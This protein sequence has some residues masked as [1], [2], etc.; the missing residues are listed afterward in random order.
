MHI[1]S[2]LVSLALT[3]LLTPLISAFSL[4]GSTIIDS[5]GNPFVMKGINHAYAFYRQQNQAFADIKS[6]GSNTI[7]I[8]L[9]GTDTLENIKFVIEESKKNKLV[10]V[11]ENHD[12]TGYGEN[13]GAKT[14]SAIAD[15]WVSMKDA[16]IGQEDYVILN[17]ANEPFGNTNFQ[18]WT[19]ETTK[20]IE[21]IR[22]A[23]IKNQLMVDGP[24]WG[25]DWSN[26]M[27]QNAPAILASD[28]LKNVVFSVH[29]YGVYKDAAKITSYIDSYLSRNLPII[30]GEFGFTHSDGEVDEATIFRYSAEKNV[31]ILAWSWSGNG[32]GVEYLDLVAGFDKSKPSAWGRQVLDAVKGATEA[33]VFGAGG[34]GAGTGTA[35][36]VAPAPSASIPAQ[37]S[38]STVSR[39]ATSA[40][41][42]A[43]VP[44][45]PS[46]TDSR[47]ATSAAP[48]Q[49]SAAPR[50]TSSGVYGPPEKCVRVGM[51]R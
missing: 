36:S 28:P 19:T 4:R 32:G 24:N 33:S 13:A 48:S 12:G 17:I 22:A 43:S 10:A 21:K 2:T 15:W 31:G 1:P 46:P 25:Q 11:V 35:T 45:Q 26:L 16:V 3:L 38:S 30:V 41:P 9:T 29:M 5:K 7:R 23:G 34:V 40:A 27:S 20:A 6:T 51:R 14:L 39:P 47:P 37:P 42:S 50:P 49:T 18:A 8:V 44:A